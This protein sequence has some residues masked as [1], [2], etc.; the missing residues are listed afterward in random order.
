MEELLKHIKDK[1]THTKFEIKI[2][3][4]FIIIL[5]DN[6]EL[7]NDK[8]F[9]DEVLELSKLYLDEKKLSRLAFVYDYLEE[10]KDV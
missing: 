7:K 1:Y 3:E 10:I 8:Y 5:Y 2:D 4:V 6:K 9:L